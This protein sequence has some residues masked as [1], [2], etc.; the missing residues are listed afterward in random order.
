MSNKDKERF[1]FNVSDAFF[2]FFCNRYYLRAIRADP[3]DSYALLSYAQFLEKCQMYNE[4]EEHYLLSL[5]VQ[6][7]T[8]FFFFC[9]SD[10][11]Y[12]SLG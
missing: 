1:L 3:T 6:E 5:E 7:E 10:A 4:A 12:I 2:F 9:F 11:L 8:L